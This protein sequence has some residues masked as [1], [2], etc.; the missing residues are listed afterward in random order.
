M[1]Q[2]C[3]LIQHDRRAVEK[4]VLLIR[5]GR[6]AVAAKPRQQVDFAQAVRADV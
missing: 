4:L 6:D 5:K 2:S 3:G 1:V